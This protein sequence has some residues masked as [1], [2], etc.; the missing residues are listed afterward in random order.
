MTTDL[1]CQAARA[2]V[3][4]YMNHE[5][6]T[7]HAQALETHI[8]GCT[9]CPA[10]YASL[11]AV[12]QHLRESQHPALSPRDVMRIAQRVSEAL[13]GEDNSPPSSVGTTF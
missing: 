7:E 6:D 9:S 1:S 2:L 10:L 3:S 13:R 5:L 8:R 12:Q 11:M 4:A